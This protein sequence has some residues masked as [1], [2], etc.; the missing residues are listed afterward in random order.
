[1]ING[2]DFLERLNLKLDGKPFAPDIQ[3]I[4]KAISDLKHQ[5][6][7]ANIHFSSHDISPCVIAETADY[8]CMK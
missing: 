3:E 5:Y 4:E 7:F 1:M 8:F 6:P 2:N